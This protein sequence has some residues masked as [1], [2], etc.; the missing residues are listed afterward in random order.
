M[1]VVCAM[2][3]RRIRV[4]DI[5]MDKDTARMLTFGRPATPFGHDGRREKSCLTE[6]DGGKN[7]VPCI[8][9]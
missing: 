1:A 6:S 7:R 8:A 2:D 9:L 4:T 5:T 3:G